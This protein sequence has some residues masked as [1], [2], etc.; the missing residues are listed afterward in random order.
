MATT[1]NKSGKRDLAGDILDVVIDG[2]RK[3]TTTIKKEERNPVSRTFRAERMTRERS[4]SM[5][6][7]AAQIMERAYL[8]VS[9]D[10][11]LPANARQIMYAA[12]PHIQRVTG[13]QLDDNYFTQTLLPDYIEETGVS[14]DVVYD[15]RGHFV[16]PR[17]YRFGIGTLEVRGYLSRQHEPS[18][19]EA[20]FSDAMVATTGPSGNFGA[21]LFIEKEGFD[22]ILAAATIA[23]RWDLAIMSTKGMSVTAARYLADKMCGRY[24]IPLLVLHD[25]DKAG[26]SIAGTLQRDTRRYEFQN[27][28]KVVELGLSLADVEAMGLESEYQHHPKADRRALVENLRTNGASDAEIAFMFRD[29]DKLRS[30]RRVELNAM[31]S[32]Q[33]VAF[34][35]R[36]L[37]E[38]GI[39]KVVPDSALLSRVYSSMEKGRRLADAAKEIETKINASDNC[40][41]PGDLEQ[42]VRTMLDKDPAMRWDDA[43]ARMV[44]E[45]ARQTTENTSS[46]VEP[47]PEVQ[48]P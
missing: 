26:F 16:E 4:T 6:E 44:A 42:R 38:N 46:A 43:V 48:A 40:A 21:V 9:G 10:G 29:F 39:A 36:K 22:P 17:G 7:A 27:T 1:K 45:S 5:K 47:A 18:V 24:K 19:M 33:F 35:E 8:K 20:G 25:F 32:P 12:R 14:W 15:A 3:W 37:Q 30:T 23:L 31:T 11:K 41:S 34:V 28:I 13:R 2:T